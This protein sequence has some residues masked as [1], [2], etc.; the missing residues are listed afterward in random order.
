MLCNYTSL[1]TRSSDKCPQL[2]RVNMRGL[3]VRTNTYVEQAD[4]ETSASDSVHLQL[5]WPPDPQWGKKNVNSAQTFRQS[6]RYL[7]TIG[8][9]VIQLL[10]LLALIVATI[11]LTSSGQSRWVHFGPRD[12]LY[13]L[14][15][16]VNSW[17]RYIIVL[18]F[19]IV[20]RLISPYALRVQL[21]LLLRHLFVSVAADLPDDDAPDL[22][23]L[24]VTQYAQTHLYTP[25]H[26][27]SHTV[28]RRGCCSLSSMLSNGLLF[29]GVAYLYVSIVIRGQVSFAQ[30]DFFLVIIL[31]EF[32]GTLALLSTFSLSESA[33]TC[34]SRLATCLARCVCIPCLRCARALCCCA[35]RH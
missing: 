32:V 19:V 35:Y 13:V 16:D 21:T 24:I 8:T 6:L 25:G 27:L 34:A 7:S 1:L 17:S 11:V 2:W 33:G 18:G 9:G 23:E 12:S 30:L 20:D 14:A 3:H 28:V 15:L 5:P 4:R 26:R 10:Y 22:S 29:L 31:F